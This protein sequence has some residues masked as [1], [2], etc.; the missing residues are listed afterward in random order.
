MRAGD[1]AAEQSRLA[2]ER[3]Q[4]L[5][6]QL[7]QTEQATKSWDDGA[8]GERIVAEHLNLLVPHGWFLLH[9]VHWPGRPRA[10]LDHVLVGP[11]GVVVVEAKNWTGEVRVSAGVLWQGRFARTQSVE[12]ALAQCAAVASVLPPPHR[13]LVRPLICLAA[14][15][16]LFAVTN[17]DVAVTGAERVVEA[18][19]SLPPVL[20]QQAVAGLYAHLSQELMQ[21]PAAEDPALRS[22]A[23]NRVA[24]PVRGPEASR[25]PENSRR[26]D[27][28]RQAD[29]SRLGST[30]RPDASR[31]ADASGRPAEP[32]DSH[33]RQLPA[34][35]AGASGGYGYR[36]ANA[37]QQAAAGIG[38][39]LC[40]AGF[41]IFAVYVLPYLG[42]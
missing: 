24:P 13:R 11:G 17:A 42:R 35:A 22:L 2:A 21:E 15:P 4:R 14:Q 1:G 5:K 8:V 20:D 38:R 32:R 33:H 9:D 28:P 34:V 39:L 26:P 36:K 31:A 6:R 30:G 12:G 41:V 3:V 10:S 40:L 7:D 37:Q 18:V 27:V 16:D 19:L 29:A 23:S 25:G